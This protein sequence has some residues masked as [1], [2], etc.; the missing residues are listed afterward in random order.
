MVNMCDDDH[1]QRRVATQ[2]LQQTEADST[3]RSHHSSKV[4]SSSASINSSNTELPSKISIQKD[5]LQ[6]SPTVTNPTRVQQ[7]PQHYEPGSPNKAT[8]T[9]AAAPLPNQLDAIIL[10][11]YLLSLLVPTCQTML[12]RI[13]GWATTTRSPQSHPNRSTLLPSS[14]TIQ[15]MLSFVTLLWTKGQ[16]P[17][18]K[19]LG[20]E[21]VSNSNN[22]N[23]NVVPKAKHKFHHR[24]IVY[25]FLSIVLPWLYDKL[26]QRWLLQIQQYQQECRLLEEGEEYSEAATEE[27]IY[28]EPV[29]ETK[30]EEENLAEGEEEEGL[31]RWQQQQ[32]Q[33]FRNST[34]AMER[35]GKRR[36]IKLMQYTIKI[37]DTIIPIS[38]LSVLLLSWLSY[39]NRNNS[40]MNQHHQQQ[41]NQGHSSPSSAQPSFALSLSEWWERCCDLL[42][43][44]KNIP[45]DL[46]MSKFLQRQHQI[47]RA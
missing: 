4:T 27:E 47:G 2:R 3:T 1:Q 13:V 23:N 42:P 30:E 38:K 18:V 31:L 36:Q 10:D 24:L 25:S 11:Q 32:Q 43:I 40:N 39:S 15:A 7:L 6:P 17:A 33:I 34:I 8:W 45:P 35:I 26:R 16:T 41:R 20:L 14:T 9:S 44:P 46:A 12:Q 5:E 28:F 21:L 37:I 19:T 22:N 29:E